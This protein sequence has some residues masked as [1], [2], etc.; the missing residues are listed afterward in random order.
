MVPT[1]PHSW[2]STPWILISHLPSHM[3]GLKV[4]D[5]VTYKHPVITGSQGCKRIVGM[6][7][8]YVCVMAPGKPMDYE[9]K[10]GGATSHEEAA[11]GE[12]REKFASYK[13]AMIRVPEGHCW[14]AGDNL[15]FSRD[16]RN[17]GP[18]P[19]NLVNGKVVALL[20]PW[21]ERKWLGHKEPGAL[22][23]PVERREE[24]RWVAI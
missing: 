8:D 18:I 14:L 15:E 5:V 12:R 9:E 7:G 19:L 3:K 10:A 17:F 11:G 24:D 16:S 4:G 6:P 21:A 22:V 20:L 2:R 1:I 23:G 13:D